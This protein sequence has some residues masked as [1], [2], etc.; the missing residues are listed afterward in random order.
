MVTV[1]DGSQLWISGSAIAP[2]R[3]LALTLD[4][5]LAAAPA[6]AIEAVVLHDRLLVLQERDLDGTSHATAPWRS[7]ARASS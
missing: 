3:V 4:A 6:D 7:R 2:P 5:L 1:Y